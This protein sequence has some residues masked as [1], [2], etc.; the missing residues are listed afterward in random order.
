MI[1]KK[2]KEEKKKKQLSI[3]R[4]LSTSALPSSTP[5]AL[6]NS[7]NNQTP[8]KPQGKPPVPPINNGKPIVPQQNAQQPNPSAN[9][10][11][12]IPTPRAGNGQS[13]QKP[14]LIKNGTVPPKPVSV[15]APK[16]YAPK[17]AIK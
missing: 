15:N 11:P 4:K 9:P 14:T 3:N 13:A 10:K 1:L 17:K 8:N 16:S 7:P 5:K 6:T 12:P 2:K